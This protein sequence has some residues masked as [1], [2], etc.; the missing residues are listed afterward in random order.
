MQPDDTSFSAPQ[1]SRLLH[2]SAKMRGP[3]KKRHDA[4]KIL[5]GERDVMALTWIGHQYGIRLDQLQVLLGRQPGPSAAQ[6]GKM[7]EGAARD[8]VKRWEKAGLVR[9]ERLL[10]KEPFWVWL[11]KAGLH[12]MSLPYR[13]RDL[14]QSSRDD[15][16]HL[17]AINAV[18]LTREQERGGQW[19]SQRQFLHAWLPSPGKHRLQRPDALFYQDEECIA[20]TVELSLKPSASLSKKLITLVRGEASLRLNSEFDEPETDTIE[21]GVRLPYAQL[22]CYTPKEVRAKIR[23]V[24]ARLV[25]QGMLSPEEAARIRLY[26]YPLAQTE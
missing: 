22:H 16:P 19:I 11:T 21:P 25:E 15:L 10:A 3:R 24:R 9:A 8:V 17:Y 20:I 1:K 18:R 26:D 2:P 7:S 4:G 14:E 5:L 13:Y 6:P 12:K 23:R